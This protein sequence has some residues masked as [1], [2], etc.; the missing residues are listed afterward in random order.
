M[1]NDNIVQRLYQGEEIRGRWWLP[2]GPDATVSGALSLDRNGHMTLT[3]ERQVNLVE[4]MQRTF[5]SERRSMSAVLGVL[6]E[7][8]LCT[9]QGLTQWGG[10]SLSISSGQ[11]TEVF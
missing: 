5:S 4:G 3:I 1:S 7:G 2:D 8:D 9:L 6:K 11:L 10:S